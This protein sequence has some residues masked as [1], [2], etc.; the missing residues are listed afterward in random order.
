MPTAHAALAKARRPAMVGGMIFTQ[1]RHGAHP[2]PVFSAGA[3]RA[4]ARV[5]VFLP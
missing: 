4:D 1:R 3:S 5:R 2:T